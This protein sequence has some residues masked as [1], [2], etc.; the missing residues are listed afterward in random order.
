M[1]TKSTETAETPLVDLSPAAETTFA[2][3]LVAAGS[4]YPPTLADGRKVIVPQTRARLDKDPAA[5]GDYGH[6]HP[7]A[8][9]P[10][11][12]ATYPKGDV[13]LRFDA[14]IDFGAVGAAPVYTLGR[15]FEQ[16]GTSGLSEHPG[17]LNVGPAS[18]V[19]AAVDLAHKLGATDVIIHGLSTEEAQALAPALVQVN[20]PGFSV[21]L[22]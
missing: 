18:P 8:L 15:D 22:V 3:V 16:G 10:H 14:A 21:R 1:K 6:R 5:E 11:V 4:S 20:A 9:P 17:A 12:K 19:F 13:Y 2:K 7:S